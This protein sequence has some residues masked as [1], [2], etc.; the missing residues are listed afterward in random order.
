MKLK[1]LLVTG[2]SL[3]PLTSCYEDYIRDSS[4]RGI[5]FANQTDVRSV[6]VGEGLRFSTAV[7]LAG[8]ISNGEDRKVDYEVDAS[9]ADGTALA[10]MKTSSLSYIASL[11]KPLTS[12]EALPS[13]EYSLV[14]EGGKDGSTIIRSGSHAGRITVVI[15][16][17]AFF[18]GS[19]SLSPRFVVP[20]RI[21]GGNG[22]DIIGGRETTVIGVRYENM[23][24]GNW[25]HGGRA[26]VKD[27]SGNV[28]DEVSYRT[29]I[30]QS[31]NRVWTLTTVDPHSLT[32]N[33]VG[34]ELNGSAAQ[35]KL[36]LREDGSVTVASVSGADY[37]VEQDG[38]CGYN[39][40]R[41]LQ[42]R[43]IYLKYRFVKDGNVWHATDTLTF[44][45]RIR[46]GVN[47]WQDENQENYK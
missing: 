18:A 27:G 29:E 30:P 13:S 31:N 17:A 19:A 38:E 32:A 12:L 22:L 47:E 28:V 34:N 14:N 41:L 40:A 44:R 7:A 23:L 36:T 45:N 37:V 2:I 25:W 9:L 42:N 46:D 5:G 33:A 1:L 11:A 16:S 4:T 43:R 15:D 21:T 24:F 26:V 3:L 10:A 6:I 35:M 8:V 20:L 39:K